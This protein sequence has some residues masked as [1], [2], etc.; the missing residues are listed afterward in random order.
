MYNSSLEICSQGYNIEQTDY[1]ISN[2]EARLNFA[3]VAYADAVKRI[4]A[5][6]LQNEALT[7]E[8]ALRVALIADKLGVETVTEC[9]EETDCCVI[10][11]ND[12]T[13]SESFI[14][15]VAEIVT[16]S[17]EEI[18]EDITNLKSQIDELKSFFRE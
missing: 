7:K 6:E 1:Y 8:L 12:M 2:L 14:E 3:E 18:E 11:D 16:D 5:L 9:N 13:A 10:N 15:P 17:D 4:K